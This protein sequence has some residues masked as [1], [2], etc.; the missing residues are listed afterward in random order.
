[1]ELEMMKNSGIIIK[2]VAIKLIDEKICS[3]I[4]LE[5]RL[6]IVVI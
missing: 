2:H 4:E 3:L 5:N 6:K 1:M